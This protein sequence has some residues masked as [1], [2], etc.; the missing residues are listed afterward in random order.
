MNSI[1]LVILIAIGW[2]VSLFWLE[3]SRQ[4]YTEKPSLA[5]LLRLVELDILSTIR[6]EFLRVL[7]TR[8]D[9]KLGYD[10]KLQN[11]NEQLNLLGGQDVS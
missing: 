3:R 10:R 4:P 2:H 8:P 1:L 5:K 7:Q 11:V 9:L 6:G